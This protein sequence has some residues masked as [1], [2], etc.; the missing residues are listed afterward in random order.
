[1]DRRRFV[2]S[3]DRDHARARLSGP[4]TLGRSDK[5]WRVFRCLPT[6]A[7]WKSASAASVG[8]LPRCSTFQT[9]HLPT[10]PL[11]HFLTSPSDPAWSGGL[12]GGISNRT[13]RTF[14]VRAEVGS[15]RQRRGHHARQQDVYRAAPYTADE[16]A[17]L[18]T[19]G[20]LSITDVR[21]LRLI[22]NRTSGATSQKKGVDVLYDW[23]RLS[24]DQKWLR[25][26]A[27]WRCSVVRCVWEEVEEVHAHRPPDRRRFCYSPRTRRELRGGQIDGSGR[28]AGYIGKTTAIIGGQRLNQNNSDAF[29]NYLIHNA[30][31]YGFRRLVMEL[32]IHP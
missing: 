20:S 13:H 25:A 18:W 10:S 21:H 4:K 2:L 1:V 29:V 19:P 12:G 9:G 32:L 7:L 23:R 26:T 5:I 11:T 16:S 24:G 15:R 8:S 28:V 27:N 6:Q 17:R 14:A 31:M 22:K 30:R 3:C